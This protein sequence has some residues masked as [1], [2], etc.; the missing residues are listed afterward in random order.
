MLAALAFLRPIGA[1]AGAALGWVVADWH[2]LLAALALL[3]IIGAYVTGDMRGRHAGDATWQAKLDRQAKDYIAAA[4]R[5]Q[6]AEHSR[7]VAAAQAAQAD[8]DKAM[9]VRDAADAANTAALEKEIASYEAQLAKTGRSCGLTDAD[10][11]AL[12]LHNP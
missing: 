6:T 10:L 5:A 11:R 1:L 8:F 4:D 7:Q 9:R 3:A 2:R 12:G